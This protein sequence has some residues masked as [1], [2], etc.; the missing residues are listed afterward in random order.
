[1]DGHGPKR[2]PLTV[3]QMLYG[4]NR[5]C[6]YCICII[7]NHFIQIQ[8]AFLIGFGFYCFVLLKMFSTVCSQAKTVSFLSGIYFAQF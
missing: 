3:R 1:M 2:M 4:V 8:Y 5:V 7:H 6:V